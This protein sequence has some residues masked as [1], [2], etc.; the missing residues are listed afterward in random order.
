MAKWSLQNK[1][2]DFDGIMAHF[3]VSAVTARLLVNRGLNEY[4]EIEQYIRPTSEGLHRPELMKNLPRLA[5]I[6][7]EK[8]GSGSKIRIIGDYD[9]DGI[10][11]TYILND[12][13]K[14][15]GA[16]VDYYIPDRIRDGY[17]IN[18]SMIEKAHEDGIDTI[19]TCDNGIAA[20]APARLAK[21]YGITLLV[22]DHHE[23]P[24]ELPEAEVIVDPKQDGETYPCRNICGAVVA[25]KL[26][27]YMLEKAGM[28][29]MGEQ[30][31]YIEFMAIATICDI[32][33]LTGENRTIAALGLTKIN[34]CYLNEDTFSV[35]NMSGSFEKYNNAGLDTINVLKTAHDSKNA[36]DNVQMPGNVLNV[37]RGLKALIKVCGIVG[38]ITEYHFGFVLGPCFNATGRLDLAARAMKLLTEQDPAR[39]EELAQ[40]CRKL[41][42]E[43]KEMTRQETQKVLDEMSA[44]ESIDRVLVVELPECHESL[45]GIIA[46]RIRENYCR[47]V[48][49]LT[50]ANEGMKGSGRSIPE[51][52]MFE[53]M[54][55]CDSLL[56]KYGGHPM[57]AGVSLPKENVA[58]F[59]R[60]LNENCTLNENDMMEKVLLDAQVSF[61]MFTPDIV[62]EIQ[63]LAPFGQGNASP[64][65]GEKNVR[66]KNIRY[67]GK[68]RNYLKMTLINDR[69]STFTALYFGE[70]AEFVG[71]LEEKYGK[72]E[73]D[74]AFSGLSNSISLILAYVPQINEYNGVTEVQ[75]RIKNFLV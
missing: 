69:N 56:T 1:K 41:N 22:T 65:F 45:A 70:A 60:V 7:S 3:G 6:L 17:G 67:I 58:E 23:V 15:L 71:K 68:N 39:A 31:P 32:V 51:Y 44:R 29:N 63:L 4:K 8:I 14:R 21:K 11:S 74:A 47:P 38:Q 37:N 2:G 61:N 75:M 10:M 53:E 35:G 25:A 20:V 52:N 64:L 19:V 48:I 5:D 50:T 62:D 43:R 26:A 54:K 18:E 28:Y 73:T 33:P 30:I 55:K 57:A 34:S 42:E 12:S 49:V 13:F 27:R 16:D 46:G 40:D 9:A 24:D 72:K 59:R 66:I 36:I